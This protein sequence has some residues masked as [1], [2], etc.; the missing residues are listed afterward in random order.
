VVGQHRKRE[1]L[2]GFSVHTEFSSSNESQPRQLLT[3]ALHQ[4]RAS[5]APATDN[6]FF[7]ARP[8]QDE[9]TEGIGE[10]AHCQLRRRSNLVGG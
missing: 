9:A 2:F 4:E 7:D 3:K 10:A 6:H 5:R 8:W 1:R